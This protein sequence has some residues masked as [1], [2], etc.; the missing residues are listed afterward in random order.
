MRYGTYKPLVNDV[1]RAVEALGPE[2][3]T[4]LDLV[5]G[6]EQMTIRA[7]APTAASVEPPLT[8]AGDGPEVAGP[9]ARYLAERATREIPART[10]P[11]A[12]GAQV[13]A[14]RDTG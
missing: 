13:P 4:R 1:A 7:F 5:R 10:V 14:A 2:L 6:R 3:R 8:V 12:R 11:T 9:G